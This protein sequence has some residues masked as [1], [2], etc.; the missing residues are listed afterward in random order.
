M[1][2]M[3]TR[4][5]PIFW[6]WAVAIIR[7]QFPSPLN[8]TPSSIHASQQNRALWLGARVRLIVFRCHQLVGIT[9]IATT[10]TMTLATQRRNA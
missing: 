5:L 2:N 3:V 9:N 8:R 4:Y 10:P 7:R 6:W 1:R